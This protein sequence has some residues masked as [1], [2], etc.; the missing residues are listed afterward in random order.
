MTSRRFDLAALFGAIDAERSR[1]GLSWAAVS[2]EVGVAAS[3]IRRYE[4][5]DDAEADGVLGLVRWLGTAPEDFV[6]G[7]SMSPS[8]PLPDGAGL[9]RVDMDRVAEVDPNRRSSRTR[10]RTTIQR[11]T[12]A[13]QRHAR[14][15]AA[16][17]RLAEQ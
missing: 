2:R 9:V 10:T 11:L 12:A 4:H 1:R 15:I 3:T 13:A 14:P 6:V 5:A 16:L 7:G 8:Q 17:T